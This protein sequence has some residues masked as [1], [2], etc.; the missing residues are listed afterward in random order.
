M[1]LGFFDQLTSKVDA[2]GRVSIPAAHRAVLASG[3]PN[4]DDGKNPY[5]ILAHSLSHKHCLRGFTLK[6]YKKIRKKISKMQSGSDK[7]DAVEMLIEMVTLVQVDDNGRIILRK[8][9]RERFG[10]SAQAV[11]VGSDDHLQIWDHDTYFENIADKGKGINP[12]EL[13][14]RNTRV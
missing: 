5:M 7:D 1:E 2:K 8:D 9:I 12:F 11:F 3:D 6:A 10:I 14:D 13:L 4:C